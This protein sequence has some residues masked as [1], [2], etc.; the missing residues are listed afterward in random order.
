MANKRAESLGI[1]QSKEVQAIY[2]LDLVGSGE[3]MSVIL[4]EA[5]HSR[6]AGEG[7]RQFVPVQHSEV[8]EAKR[9]LTPRSVAVREHQTEN[10]RDVTVFISAG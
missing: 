4:L 3:N 7:A 6:Q 5:S 1:S 9:Q 10:K 2:L 8:G